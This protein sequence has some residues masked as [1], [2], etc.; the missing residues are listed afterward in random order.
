[1]RYENGTPTNRRLHAA[2]Y[3][4]LALAFGF[5]GL[6][7]V[8]GPGRAIDWIVPY[9]VPVVMILGVVVWLFFL[10]RRG[11]GSRDY[12]DGNAYDEWYDRFKG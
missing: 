2:L 9:L 3:T 5:A 4:M 11:G 12:N 1:M 7:A 8:V 10:L 6:V